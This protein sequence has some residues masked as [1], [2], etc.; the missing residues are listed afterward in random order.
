MGDYDGRVE[1]HKPGQQGAPSI[2]TISEAQAEVSEDFAKPALVASD[3]PVA[4]PP[5]KEASPACTPLY[6]ELP[7][8]VAAQIPVETSRE[9]GN[10][11]PADSGPPP[12]TFQPEPEL[13]QEAFQAEVAPQEAAA[14]A[15][16][17]EPIAA[18]ACTTDHAS[19][20]TDAAP[21]EE[22]A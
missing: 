13:Q 1:T 15:L 8:P 14:P 21:E 2:P 7:A 22:A 18:D 12:P 9:A 10:S 16:A 11:P 17:D 4:K 6:D 20:P 19:G 3:C 5:P